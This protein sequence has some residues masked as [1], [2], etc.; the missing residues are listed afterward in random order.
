[1][2]QNLPFLAQKSEK[3]FWGGHSPLPDSCLGGERDTPPTPHPSRRLWRL[4][5]R[6]Y[7]ARPRPLGALAPA[8]PPVRNR[9]HFSYIRFRKVAR[10]TMHA[11]VASVTLAIMSTCCI[12][13]QMQH[14]SD[15]TRNSDLTSQC[16]ERH[17][18]QPLFHGITHLIIR[19]LTNGRSEC[20]YFYDDNYN[21]GLWRSWIH[22]SQWLFFMHKFY[23]TVFGNVHNGYAL[24][25]RAWRP[26]VCPLVSKLKLVTLVDCD[27]VWR[28]NKILKSAYFRI[29]QCL[30][31][32]H[33]KTRSRPGAWYS[34]I[35][36]YTKEDQWGIENV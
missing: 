15:V 24:M 17:S 3:N 34:V 16:T 8:A 18:T 19:N 12:W 14:V 9:L 7:G 28:C 4:I 30:G 26:P 33:D 20:T 25:L 31:Y 29:D 22:E 11:S 21:C 5:S 36:D 27:H 1:M 10:Q 35:P 13:L 6:A 2:H 23:F 32:L